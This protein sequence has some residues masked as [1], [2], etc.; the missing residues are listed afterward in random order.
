MR[1]FIFG[2][3]YTARAL[4]DT[5]HDRFS[6]ISGTVRSPEK[7]K[8]LNALGISA[9][10]FAPNNAALIADIVQADAILASIPPGTGRDPALTLL[11]EHDLSLRAHWI[12]YLSTVGVYGDHAGAWVDEKSP[13]LTLNIRSQHR[14]IAEADWRGV[15]N[16]LGA[17][18]FIF[19]LP[20]I[21]GPGR[22]NLR[23]IAK[24]TARHIIKADQVFNRA[25]VEDIAAGIIATLTEEVPAGIYNLTDDEPASQGDVVTYAAG[26]MGI[27]PPPPVHFEAAEMS[28]MARS[29]YLENKRVSNAKLRALP[30]FDLTF[31]TYREGL[32]ALLQA[33]EGAITD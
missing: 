19:R 28:E 13:T 24:G 21:Y 2:I 20:G 23:D 10:I 33:G 22:N 26:I 8:E 4:I 11:S 29:F 31:P 18:D 17:R 12:G 27:E 15:A 9:H 25:H 32:A 16:T 6:Y 5:H 1:L 3:G 7:A 14:L 30:A